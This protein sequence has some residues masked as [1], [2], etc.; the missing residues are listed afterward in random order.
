MHPANL[1]C[2]AFWENTHWDSH[3]AVLEGLIVKVYLHSEYLALWSVGLLASPSIGVCC[4]VRQV[5]REVLAKFL[6]AC[7][8]AMRGCWL[9]LLG[10]VGK[11]FLQ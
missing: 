6:T 1:Y 5:P 11:D 4:V 7:E 8:A 2:N 10:I 3:Q 9:H